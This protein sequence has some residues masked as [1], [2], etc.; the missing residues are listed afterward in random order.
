MYVC[1]CSLT[2]PK[3]TVTFNELKFRKM[4]LLG[5]RVQNFRLKKSGFGQTEKNVTKIRDT[6]T[7]LTSHFHFSL[8]LSLLDV[9]FCRCFG[10]GVK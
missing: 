4:V 5:L 10:G 9:V 3:Q 6:I 2:T 1:V 7:R 8:S